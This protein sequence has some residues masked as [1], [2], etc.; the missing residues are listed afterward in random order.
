MNVIKR[1]NSSDVIIRK[2][3]ISDIA[4]LVGLL[5]EL[6]SIEEDFVFDEQKQR[7]GLRLTLGDQNEC[8][9]M[10]AELNEKVV[11]MCSAQTLFSTSEGGVV[12]IVEDM[13]VSEEC[14]EKGIGKSLLRSIETWAK[15]KGL[16]RL[17]LLA[18]KNNTIALGF[19]EKSDWTGTQLICLRKFF[20]K[21]QVNP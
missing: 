16:T 6:C 13:V 19:Y 3:D 4:G 2:A 17:Q 9:V 15:E 18:D 14:R 7:K 10:V 20:T 21:K 12:G 8:C 1:I 11:G 5:E